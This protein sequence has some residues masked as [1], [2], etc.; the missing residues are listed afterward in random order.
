MANKPK[1]TAQPMKSSDVAH[2]QTSRLSWF[3]RFR[4]KHLYPEQK[5]ASAL[6]KRSTTPPTHLHWKLSQRSDIPPH[7]S[8]GGAGREAEGRDELWTS[9]NRSYSPRALESSIAARLPRTPCAMWRL[10]TTGGR[11]GQQKKHQDRRLAHI[12]GS[13]CHA[14]DM[15]A[16]TSSWYTYTHRMVVVS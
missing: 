5:F 11:G 14:I 4:T 15:P 7:S 12:V 3:F 13:Q 16:R 10:Y 8:R 6:G 9:R 1:E 2:V